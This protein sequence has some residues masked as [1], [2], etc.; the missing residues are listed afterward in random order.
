MKTNYPN[1]EIIVVDNGSS[2]RSLHL[3]REEYPTINVIP[4]GSNKGVGHAYNA[5]MEATSAEFVS[6]LNNDIEVDP[7][8]LRP[9]VLRIQNDSKLAGCDSKY[10]NYFNRTIID[11][12]GGAGRFIDR[13]GNSFN[14]GGGETDG[15]PYNKPIEV[16]YGMALFKKDL[17]KMVGG[18]D[19]RFFAY[20]DE[21]D[22]CWRLHRLGYKIEY[23][24]QSV[25][26]H[27]GSAT[28]Y[29]SPG[30]M[31][32]IFTFHFF[33]NR[34]RMLIKNQFGR[35]LA[36]SLV[37]YL[38]DLFGITG[39]W[40][41]KRRHG[42]IPCLAK[43]LLWNLSNLGNTLQHRIRVKNEYREYERLFVPYSGIWRGILKSF[44][45][46]LQKRVQER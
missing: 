46:N 7:N 23:V 27:M 36:L 14:R 26:F 25:I 35:E 44:R 38:C 18:Y 45:A 43:A 6:F 13:F 28:T 9:L 21:T 41:K 42:D 30:N 2:D 10:L 22:L 16:F 24:P 17:V 29:A 33:K 37:V 34:L 12:S 39:M 20:Y 1:F 3:L 4:L 11:D 31:K 40:V 5:A 15:E 32:P 8:W 19:E